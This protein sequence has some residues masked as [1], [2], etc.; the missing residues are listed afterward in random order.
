M[1]RGKLPH[2][3]RTC[4]IVLDN[5]TWKRIDRLLVRV[6][7]REERPVSRS[8]LLRELVNG[9]IDRAEELGG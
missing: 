7:R 8:E 9:A 4:S 6:R 5:R 1:P 2:G 3:A